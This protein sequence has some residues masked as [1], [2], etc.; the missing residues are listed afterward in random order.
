MQQNPE[1]LYYVQINPCQFV[2]A[3]FA[4]GRGFFML[5]RVCFILGRTCLIVLNRTYFTLGRT[6]FMLGRDGPPVP[7]IGSYLRIIMPCLPHS[8]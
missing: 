7:H 2:H 4:L 5:D 8:N 1:I 3:C 6:C